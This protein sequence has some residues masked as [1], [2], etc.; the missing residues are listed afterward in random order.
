M[1]IKIC[2]L[3]DPNSPYLPQII[4]WQYKTWGKKDGLRYDCVES[5]IRHSIMK[6]RI[7]LTYCSCGWRTC[8]ISS[9]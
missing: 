7:P 6:D 2:Q 9:N 4:K 8:W 5:N 1:E 3:T